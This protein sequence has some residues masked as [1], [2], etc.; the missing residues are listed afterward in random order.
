MGKTDIIVSDATGL[1][2]FGLRILTQ[3]FYVITDL[4]L[5]SKVQRHPSISFDPLVLLAAERLCGAS[6]NMLQ[7]MRDKTKDGKKMHDSLMNE[8]HVLTHSMLRSQPIL[9]SMVGNMLNVVSNELDHVQTGDLY[10]WV[11]RTVCLASTDAL[12][13]PCNPFRL[14]P[15]LEDIF[16]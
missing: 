10:S 2:I 3:R 16:W 1:P 4:T 5:V 15:E 8:A 9:S 11:R 13:G 14:N 7:T 12:Y 6:K